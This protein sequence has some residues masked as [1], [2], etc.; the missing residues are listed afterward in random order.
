[1]LVGTRQKNFN[2]KEEAL[3]TLYR[4]AMKPHLGK[5]VAMDRRGHLWRTRMTSGIWDY[6][7]AR[8][9]G[10]SWKVV[11]QPGNDDRMYGSPIQRIV[12]DSSGD[13]WACGEG[14]IYTWAE[15]KWRRA[16]G[17]DDQEWG[18]GFMDMRATSSGTI[19]A[20]GFEGALARM[21]AGQWHVFDA[22]CEIPLCP[23]YAILQEDCIAETAD[24]KLWFGIE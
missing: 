15:D 20:F 18:L 24:G 9:D 7:I 8:F 23:F 17:P 13:V 1:M 2:S 10:R 14:G 22:R 5:V 3:A 6:D 12:T 4:T 21:Q 19:W 11:D 16:I